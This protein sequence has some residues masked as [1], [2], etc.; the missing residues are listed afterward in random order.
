VW[1][2]AV[3][4]A[5]QP[6]QPR[7]LSRHVDRTAARRIFAELL[8]NYPDLTAGDIRAAQRFAADYLASEEVIWDRPAAE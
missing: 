7:Y 2:L 4:K 6:P 1:H 3:E 5:S 8:A